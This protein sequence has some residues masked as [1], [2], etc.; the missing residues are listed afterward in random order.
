VLHLNKGCDV[1]VCVFACNIVRVC[2]T[3]RRGD[4]LLPFLVF[5]G[6]EDGEDD[7]FF[8]PFSQLAPK[9]SLCQ[10]SR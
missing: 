7:F 4:V 6:K 8:R 9:Q 5:S 10:L 1:C 3:L 2:Y